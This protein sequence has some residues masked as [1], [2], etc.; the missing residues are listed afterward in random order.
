MFV[1]ETEAYLESGQR[2][3]WG[4]ERRRVET[5]VVEE[6]RCQSFKEQ[7]HSREVCCL[8]TWSD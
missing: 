3:R 7:S 4:Q 2:P 5:V 8:E 6:S 1:D